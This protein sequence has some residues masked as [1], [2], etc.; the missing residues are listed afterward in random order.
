MARQNV[1]FKQLD[2][3]RGLAGADSE[4]GAKMGLFARAFWYYRNPAMS[5]GASLQKQK[6][7][8]TRWAL[9]GKSTIAWL[10]TLTELT[11]R[12]REKRESACKLL[13]KALT[14]LTGTQEV[15]RF[16]GE[17]RQLELKSRA[18][19]LSSWNLEA[20]LKLN[21]QCALGRRPGKQFSPDELFE[22]ASASAMRDRAPVMFKASQYGLRVQKWYKEFFGERKLAGR[23][24]EGQ[25]DRAAEKPAL[26]SMGKREVGNSL[27]GEK[28]RHAEAVQLASQSSTTKIN[29]EPMVQSIREVAAARSSLPSSS[30]CGIKRDLAA[31]RDG[32]KDDMQVGS[33]D[34]I[35]EP[36]LK[37]QKVAEKQLAVA[38]QT[39]AGQCIPYVD[40]AGRQYSF[41]IP[42][43]EPAAAVAAPLPDLVKLYAGTSACVLPR[44]HRYLA[45]KAVMETD[46]VV[47]EDFQRDFFCPAALQARLWGKRLADREWTLKKMRGGMSLAFATALQSHLHLFFHETFFLEHPE[48]QRVVLEAVTAF[49]KKSNRSRCLQAT[50]GNL[51]EKPQHPRLSWQVVSTDFLEKA[52]AAGQSSRLLDLQLLTNR[53]TEVLRT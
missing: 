30:S 5:S 10:R 28:R 36:S 31:S 46:V 18:Q 32:A 34:E 2:P 48:H 27:A 11:A 12:Q 35:G 24:L 16:L 37:A 3:R 9:E 49:A 52:R 22:G 1:E 17:V 14:V 13:E 23:A 20:S 26:G 15:E 33:K 41:K 47:L 44:W 6:A 42:T 40:A 43:P 51:P 7:H 38:K 39:P 8:G 50:A 25:R 21:C 29:F 19:H 53:L 45:A 4:D